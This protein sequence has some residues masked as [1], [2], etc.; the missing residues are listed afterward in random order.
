V[1][2]P[3]KQDC[4]KARAGVPSVKNIHNGGTNIFSENG[5]RWYH[6]RKSIMYVF[7]PHHTRSMRDVTMLKLED[8]V[9]NLDA[10]EGKGFDVGKEMIKHFK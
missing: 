2:S 4:N 9:V 10:R 8:F 5:E 1:E 6:A 3:H 7:S